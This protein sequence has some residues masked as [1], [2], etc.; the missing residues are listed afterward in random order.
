MR[1]PSGRIQNVS[2]LV[3]WLPSGVI[4]PRPL[5]PLVRACRYRV[6]GIADELSISPRI[7]SEAFES[8]LGIG[9]KE[10]IRQVRFHDTIQ[11]FREKRDL[12]MITQTIGF[13]YRKELAREIRFFTGMNMEEF[14][15]MLLRRTS[16][17]H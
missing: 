7:L 10:W 15:Q 4:E 17:L 16:Q 12:T 11:L 5:L 6:S 2:G 3:T 14:R 13:V 9:V 8:G 1:S